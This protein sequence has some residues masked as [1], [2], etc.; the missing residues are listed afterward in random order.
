ML[1]FFGISLLG[2]GNV[3]I[4]VFDE[5]EPEEPEEPEEEPLLLS[6]L[7]ALSSPFG[8]M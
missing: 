5:E 1:G 3:M 6:F 2:F 7:E 4:V 8:G